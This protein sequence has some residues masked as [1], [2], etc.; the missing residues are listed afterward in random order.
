MAESD[1]TLRGEARNPLEKTGF[2]QKVWCFVFGHDEE[3][4]ELEVNYQFDPPVVLGGD[5]VSELGPAMEAEAFCGRCG[6]L[7]W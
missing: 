2:G 1:R 5:L 7:F 6:K 3:N 4:W